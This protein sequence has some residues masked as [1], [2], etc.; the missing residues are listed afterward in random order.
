MYRDGNYI[1][2]ISQSISSCKDIECSAEGG[3]YRDGYYIKPPTQRISILF[4]R[5][6]PNHSMTF[7]K[8]EQLPPVANEDNHHSL[9]IRTAATPKQL[10]G[11]R[12][13]R[14]RR[15]VSR[16]KPYPSNITTHL[17]QQGHLD[18]YRSASRYY[19]SRASPNHSMT[20]Y[21]PE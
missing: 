3:M 19:L 5:A 8:P 15:N 6:S 16:W 18:F 13:F 7:C 9:Q 2:A 21:K 17:E 11:H 14:R 20:F 12:V 1:Q 10:Q 4:A